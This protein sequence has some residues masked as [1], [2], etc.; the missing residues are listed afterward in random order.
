MKHT[1]S[2]LNEMTDYQIN[3]AVALKLGLKI[4]D[5]AVTRIDG[6]QSVRLAPHRNFNPCNNWSDVMPIIKAN[7]IGINNI[8]YVD[9]VGG[10]GE[11]Q[12]DPS[13]AGVYVEVVEGGGCRSYWLE[14]ENDNLLRAA[15]EV[16]LMLDETTAQ[17]D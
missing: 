4:F 2:K 9:R 16:F 6:E 11:A 3:Y 17:P 8:T 13:S 12:Q 5:G 1:N 7:K 10:L 14:S 15:M